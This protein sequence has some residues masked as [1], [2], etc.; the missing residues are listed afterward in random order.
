MNTSTSNVIPLEA[1][2][3]HLHA[4]SANRRKA[5]REKTPPPAWPGELFDAWQQM[6]RPW[7]TVWGWQEGAPPAPAERFD[8]VEI[9]AETP[10]A[11][12]DRLMRAEMGR[13]TLGISPASLA[14]AYYDWAVH[15][16]LSPGKWQQLVHKAGTKALR[17]N[18]CAQHSLAD[19]DYPPCIEPLEQDHRFRS[20]AWQKLP[21]KLIWQSFLLTQ[22]WWHV[23]TTSVGGVSEHHE[24]VVSFITRQLL[25][26]V[27]PSNLLPC[28]PDLL[29]ATL[30][31]NGQNLWR[32]GQYFIEDCY[33]ALA[34]R[35]PGGAA[36]FRPGQEVALTPG[37][38]IYRNELIELIQY[39]PRT[40]QVYAEPV[41]IVPAWIMKYYILDL[42]PHNSLVRYLTERG[43]TVF[44]ISWHNPG[45]QDSDLGMDDYLHKGLFAALRTVR[46]IVPDKPVHGIGYCLGGTLLAIAAAY[47]ARQSNEAL[48]SMTLLAAQTDFSE[49]GELMLF[50]DD[51]QLAFLEDIMWSQGYLDTKQM[52]GA[53]Q[54]LRS[55]DLIWSRMVKEYLMGERDQMNDLMAWNAD[56]TR[57]PYRMHSEYLRRFFLRNDLF[58]GRYRVDGK[59]IALSDIRV[60]IF[61]VAT[62]KDHVAPWRSVYKLKLIADAEVSFLLVSGGHNA[63]IIS[64]PG[65]A[66]RSYRIS[67]SSADQKYVDPDSWCAATPRQEGSWWPEMDDWLVQR[68]SGKVPARLPGTV[69]NFPSLGPAPGRYVLER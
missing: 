38:V 51:S 9:V 25:D 30:G 16:A 41:L 26:M 42:S 36:D 34:G 60:P 69:A 37:E 55:N 52:A 68:S 46:A 35:P 28:N 65:H 8:E 29:Q 39:R 59:P 40:E 6:L 47:L 13:F 33:L 2:R 11:N 57:M 64:E 44:M 15:L 24:R 20:E 21:F 56:A 49:A 50:I 19:P 5:P 45:P 27:S 23:A 61:M 54:L 48:A 14:L 63:G 17:F 22:Q 12:L 53:F 7:F 4:V 1:A 66:H 62:E 58:E 18:H 67:H 31:E 3:V 32:G 43:H 10:L